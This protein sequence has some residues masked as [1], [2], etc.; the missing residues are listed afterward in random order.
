MIIAIDTGG[1]KTLIAGFS[2]QG[3]LLSSIKFETPKQTKKYLETVK[4][5][6]DDSFSD[7]LKK[8]E[9]KIISAAMPALTEDGVVIWAQNLRWKNFD[10]KT[11]LES[12]FP[13]IPVLIENDANLAGLSEAR[14]LNKP[15]KTVLYI[16]VSTGIGAG[17]ITDNYINEGL[18]KSESGRII[19]EYDGV[20]REWEQFASGKAIFNTYGKYTKDIHKPKTWL[21]IADK[22]SRGLLV[23]IPIIQPNIIIIGGSVGGQFDRFGVFLNAIV[24]D[25]LPSNIP[26]PKIVSAHN[27]K[28]AV[29]FGCYEYAKDHLTK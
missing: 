15:E 25:R 22:I 3:K 10:V 19:I 18:R 26:C 28:E 6:I 12:L 14:L 27:P 1:T 11:E 24:K 5:T 23:M 8:G 20:M 4:K 2:D 21:S 17:I 9:V 7:Y 13:K 29:I 16:T